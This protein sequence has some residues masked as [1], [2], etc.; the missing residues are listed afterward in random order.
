MIF[1]FTRLRFVTVA[2]GLFLICGP[3]AYAQNTQ[4]VVLSINQA[5][6]AGIDGRAWNASFPGALTVDAVH[7]SILVRFPTAAEEIK[8]KLDSGLTILRTELVLDYGD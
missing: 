3:A 6:T 5:Q 7:R 2:L 8:S 1:R 4:A